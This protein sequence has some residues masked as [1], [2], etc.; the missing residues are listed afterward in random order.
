MHLCF[1]LNTLFNYCLYKNESLFSPL[2]SVLDSFEFI[3]NLSNVKSVFTIHLSENLF[4]NSS[5]FCYECDKQML[6][7]FKKYKQEAFYMCS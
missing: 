4:N 3:L 1:E 5:I 7:F 6:E 2:T